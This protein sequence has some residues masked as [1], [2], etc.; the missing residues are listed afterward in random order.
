MGHRFWVP[1]QKYTEVMHQHIRLHKIKSQG[2]MVKLSTKVH[3]L[4]EIVS[5]STASSRIM[6]R[7]ILEAY[8]RG[9]LKNS[10]CE[11]L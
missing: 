5:C 6:V 7:I 10:A 9:N 2:A 11:V 1:L 8:I 3:V 4:V